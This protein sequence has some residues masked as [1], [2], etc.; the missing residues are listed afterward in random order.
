MSG[1]LCHASSASPARKEKLFTL[2]VRKIHPEK[3]DV[4][5]RRNPFASRRVQTFNL[6]YTD[7]RRCRRTQTQD[8]RMQMQIHACRHKRMLMAIARQ[9]QSKCVG[10]CNLKTRPDVRRL[11]KEFGMHYIQRLTMVE[12]FGH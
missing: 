9:M 8:M 4:S 11:L 2:S 12:E 10:G 6:L 3:R 7:A 1:M 5:R